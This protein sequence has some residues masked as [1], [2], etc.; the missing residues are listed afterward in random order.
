MDNKKLF[1]YPWYELQFWQVDAQKT[2]LKQATRF[3]NLLKLC[4]TFVKSKFEILHFLVN[5]AIYEVKI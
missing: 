1:N 3:A 5:M 2:G 4:L